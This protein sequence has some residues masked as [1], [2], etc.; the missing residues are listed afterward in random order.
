MRFFL[1]SVATSHLIGTNHK[2]GTGVGWKIGNWFRIPVDVHF[3]GLKH[4]DNGTTILLTRN[5]IDMVVSAYKWHSNSESGNA[6]G[7]WLT[8]AMSV[9]AGHKNQ[10]QNAVYSDAQ[11]IRMY[12]LPFVFYDESYNDYLRRISL[13]D[14]LKAEMVRCLVRDVPY[15]MNSLE[16]E[17]LED[18]TF[19]QDIDHA[20]IEDWET[21]G[22]LLGENIDNVNKLPLM[23]HNVGRMH[24]GGDLNRRELL[25]I[26]V[27]AIDKEWFS[28]VYD[29]L[30]AEYTS[31]YRD[32]RMG[33][34]HEHHVQN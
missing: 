2:T 29:N 18:D 1:L 26:K 4:N 10:G 5:P 25:K 31:M 32:S 7:K 21:V 28:G 11:F 3:T 34:D 6:E 23:L 33:L 20:T 17:F 24:S 8:D 13:E 15:L 14:G 22:W 12:D 30:E 19:I 27:R 16:E 9:V